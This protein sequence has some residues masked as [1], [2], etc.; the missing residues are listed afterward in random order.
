MIS[1]QQLTFGLAYSHVEAHQDD[2]MAFH[3]LSFPSQLNCRMD[4]AAK[5]AIIDLIDVV[6]P[7][8]VF[9]LESVAVFVDK[10]KMTSSTS[11]VLLFWACRRLAKQAFHSLNFLFADQ[12]E[13][14]NWPSVFDGLHNVP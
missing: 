8:E 11:G 14:I 12:F 2:T 5:Q 1:C 4:A 6:L 3:W 9:P 13:E 7:Q 10:E